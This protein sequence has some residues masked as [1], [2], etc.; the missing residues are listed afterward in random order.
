[1]EVIRT[2]KIIQDTEFIENYKFKCGKIV[3]IFQV[4]SIYALSTVIGY[5]KY[6]N[7]PHGNV[8]YRGQCK[9]YSTIEP[10]IYRGVE[11]E[12]SKLKRNEKLNSIIKKAMNDK[13]FS[14]FMKLD[15]RD[16]RIQSKIRLESTLQHYGIPTHYVDLVDNH[17]VA[18]WFGANQYKAYMNGTLARY[19][20]RSM[21]IG[22]IFQKRIEL[23]EDDFKRYLVDAKACIYQYLLLIFVSKPEDILGSGVS[24]CKDNTI[25]VDLRNALPSTFLR[26]HAQHGWTMQRGNINCQHGSDMANNVVGILRIRVSDACKWLGD[27]DL[28]SQEGLFPNRIYDQGYNVLLNHDEFF[29]TTNW[30]IPLMI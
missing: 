21:D 17:W 16:D 29:K 22:D 26:P 25:L 23:S 5:I 9:L 20:K 15:N 12:R 30:K 24:I 27:G 6:I 10:S 8:L 28:L 1:M 2:D 3:P 4:N 13:A 19:E 7:A 18:L 11:V 14:K